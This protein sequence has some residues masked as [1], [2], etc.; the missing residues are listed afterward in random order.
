MRCFI[1]FSFSSFIRCVSELGSFRFLLSNRRLSNRRLSNRRLSNPRRS[2]CA[3]QPRQ[4]FFLRIL[5]SLLLS[6]ALLVQSLP[7]FFFPVVVQAQV[8]GRLLGLRSV[9]LHGLGR[10][11]GRKSS[12]LLLGCKVRLPEYGLSMLYLCGVQPEFFLLLG[13]PRLAF[14]LLV[15]P[16]PELLIAHE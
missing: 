5:L 16:M 11:L 14:F 4:I 8:A 2:L 3:Q 6:S 9:F 12:G 13:L 15:P 10:Q 7:F 1:S